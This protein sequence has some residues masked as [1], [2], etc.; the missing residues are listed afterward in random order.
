MQGKL[1]EAEPLYKRA[2]KTREKAFKSNYP[3]VAEELEKMAK[4]YKEMGKG[5]EAKRFEERARKIRL[6]TTLET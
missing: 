2:L 5:D 4:L 1:V 3:E 6:K